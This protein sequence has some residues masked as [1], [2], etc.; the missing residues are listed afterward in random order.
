MLGV[1]T[2]LGV[3]QTAIPQFSNVALET[4]ELD[5]TQLVQ[6][7]LLVQFIALPGAILVGWL[8][9]IWSRRART[10]VCLAGQ[11]CSH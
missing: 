8:S 7:V 9:G 11:W 4:F 5:P 1:V 3:V 6:L 10:S 2:V